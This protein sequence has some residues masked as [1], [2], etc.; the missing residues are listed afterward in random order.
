MIVSLEKQLER[1][2][3]DHEQRKHLTSSLN[4]AVRSRT[5]RLGPKNFSTCKISVSPHDQVKEKQKMSCGIRQIPVVS[6]DAITGHKL[7]GLTKDNIIVYSWNKLTE[8]IYVVLS[9]V[10]T[11]D[12]LYLVRPLKLNDITLPSKS[13]LD[14]LRRM[15]DMQNT[16]LQR[17]RDS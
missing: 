8:W 11:M 14:F 9:R 16:E 2:D 7:Q 10:K 15:K 12:G 1:D 6:S 17:F 13:Y 3:I 4:A 5:F